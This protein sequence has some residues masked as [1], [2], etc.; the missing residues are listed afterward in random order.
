MKP[1]VRIL[2]A[3]RRNIGATQSVVQSTSSQPSQQTPTSPLMSKCRP[4]L[5]S[6][7][8]I[9]SPRPVAIDVDS[10]S[11]DGIT[12]WQMDHPDFKVTLK[13]Q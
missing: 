7:S 10:L 9:Q 1:K 12:D 8:S 5:H 11:L 6:T 13:E 4:I 2:G 3:K